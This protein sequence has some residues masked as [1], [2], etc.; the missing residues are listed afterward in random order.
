MFKQKIYNTSKIFNDE[1]KNTHE[2][3]VNLTIVTKTF[4]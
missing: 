2:V 1:S 4:H 3:Y